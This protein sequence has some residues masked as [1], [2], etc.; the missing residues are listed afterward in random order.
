MELPTGGLADRFYSSG[1]C[2]RILISAQ[3]EKNKMKILEL[4]DFKD[5]KINGKFKKVAVFVPETS[6]RFSCLSV[7]GQKVCIGLADC[8]GIT[9]LQLCGSFSEDNSVYL[10]SDDNNTN[11]VEP[12]AG[13]M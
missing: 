9:F 5:F 10:E 8:E 1:D 3:D 7:D 11:A 6:P 13:V 2:T 12:A 4:Y